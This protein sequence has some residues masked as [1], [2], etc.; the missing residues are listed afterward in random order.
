MQNNKQTKPVAKM[1]TV[2]LIDF[3]RNETL[4]SRECKSYNFAMG[5]LRRIAYKHDHYVKPNHAK[6]RMVGFI[7]KSPYYGEM[8]VNG[9]FMA[10]E[11]NGY[12]AIHPDD[13]DPTW[14]GDGMTYSCVPCNDEI[15]CITNG[16]YFN[17]DCTVV[18][19]AEEASNITKDWIVI[20]WDYG[21]SY[22]NPENSSIDT[23]Q[24]DIL[25]NI[26][27]ILNS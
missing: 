24:K 6:T 7:R 1:S 15:T 26:S 9:R 20:G 4:N 8:F 10:G 2:E 12:I 3:L 19:G 25:E 18:Y 17:E 21:H 22:N 5:I 13:Y 14:E 11:Y 23:V 16:D 27:K